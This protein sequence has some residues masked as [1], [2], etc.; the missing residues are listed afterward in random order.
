VAP[1]VSGVEPRAPWPEV[2]KAPTIGAF[3]FVGNSQ[4]LDHIMVSESLAGRSAFDVLRINAEFAQ[5]TS[6]HDPL[7]ARL[8]SRRGL[9]LMAGTARIR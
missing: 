7:I 2:C 8:A 5:Q 6:D 4:D 3:L 9:S 1:S